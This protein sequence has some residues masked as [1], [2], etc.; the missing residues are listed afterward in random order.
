MHT[1]TASYTCV[2]FDP[3]RGESVLI[4]K[5]Y[6]DN[7]SLGLAPASQP[8]TAVC[9]MSQPCFLRLSCAVQ[10]YVWGKVGCESEVALLKRGG[11]HVGPSQFM[12][13]DQEHYA[14]VK[15]SPRIG[16]PKIY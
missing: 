14:E 16:K 2:T 12:V 3:R 13:D 5:P 6:C 7:S 4:L 9:T 11:D 10:N 15:E 8:A 1:A